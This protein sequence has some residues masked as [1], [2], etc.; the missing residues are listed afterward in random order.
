[1]LRRSIAEPVG[2]CANARG[3][4]RNLQLARPGLR[5]FCANGSQRGTCCPMF[6]N[7]AV[8]RRDG[9]GATERMHYVHSAIDQ[10]T[11]SAHGGASPA[12]ISEMKQQSEQA[13]AFLKALAHE[14]RLLILCHLATGEKSVGQLEQLLQQRQA[15]VS[16]QLARLRM[17]G[18]VQSRREGKT[19]FYSIGDPKA[20]R[21]IGLLYD[22]FC[23][24]GAD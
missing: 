23:G 11:G 21:M 19:I 4:V 9:Q 14:G 3:I 10:T 6:P 7:G 12:L 8:T 1:M 2:L 17:E 16:Q 22:M 15:A 13:A 5:H 18:L 24:D 20:Q